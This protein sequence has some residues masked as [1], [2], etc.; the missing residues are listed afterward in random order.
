MSS[1]MCLNC[2]LDNDTSTTQCSACFENNPRLKPLYKENEPKSYG[3]I[4]NKADHESLIYGYCR[5]VV[6]IDIIKL[7]LQFYNRSLFWMVSYAQFEHLKAMIDHD[8]EAVTNVRYTI[9]TIQGLTISLELQLSGDAKLNYAIQH[10]T[11]PSDIESMNVNIMM[12]IYE[13]NAHW[14][15]NNTFTNWSSY[16]WR[17]Y[18]LPF[19]E[20]LKYKQLTVG[21]D[22]EVLSVQYY[23]DMNE[24]E[25]TK[26]DILRPITLKDDITICKYEWKIDDEI[27][28][29]FINAYNGKSF[30]QA[31]A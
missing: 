15:G 31:H 29:D 28:N 26:I 3:L 1:W 23:G 5:S 16:S 10:A 20:C 6:P 14:R 11:L 22:I 2:G 13:P 17:R 27:L 19:V 12:D 24:N 30:W 4:M 25:S 18:T 9:T 7:I 21:C 8:D